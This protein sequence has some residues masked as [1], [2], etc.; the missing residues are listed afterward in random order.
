MKARM[1]AVVWRVVAAGL[2]ALA[3]P[4]WGQVLQ[5]IP[6]L[7]NTGVDD[8]GALLAG[9]AVDPH[10]SLMGGTAFVADPNGEP[11]WVANSLTSQWIAP[12]A[13]QDPF[14]G[15]SFPAGTYTYR[16]TFDLGGFD[17]ESALI[18]GSWA[19]DNSGSILLNGAA[20]GNLSGGFAALVPF[21]I[22][23]GFV[24]GTNTLDFAV[25]NDATPPGSPNPNLTGL[26][27]E[28]IT[29][30]AMIPEPETYALL[31]AGIGLLGFAAGRRKKC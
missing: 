14:T 22:S 12:S 29:G 2:L 25:L 28:G 15:D 1:L 4:A 17:P 26:R 27:V 11:F 7:F 31:L 3:L 24:A 18:T 13:D 16:L 19:A 8:S 30:V 10:Y 5:P 20:T 21:T 6:G 23:D 9:G